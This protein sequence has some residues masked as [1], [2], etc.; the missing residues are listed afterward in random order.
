LPLTGVTISTEI[1][2]RLG[3]GALVGK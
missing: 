2:D 3:E 1:D